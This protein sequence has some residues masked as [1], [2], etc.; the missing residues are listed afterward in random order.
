VSTPRAALRLAGTAGVTL[1]LLLPALVV[2]VARTVRLLREATALRALLRLQRLWSR[3][4]LGLLGVRVRLA[5]RPPDHGMLIVSNHL[6]YLDFPV[7]ASVLPCRFVAKREVAGWPVIGWLARLYRVLFLDRGRRRALVD[8]GAEVRR[9]LQ[10]GVA[11]VVF[12]EGTS[13]AGERVRPFHPGLLQ[14]AVEADAECLPLAIHYETPGDERPPAWTICWWGE[15]TFTPHV[16]ELMKTRSVEATL[17]FADRPERGDDRKRLAQA[18]HAR[19]GEL[20]RP[21]RQG[22]WRST[23][24]ELIEPCAR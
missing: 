18:L 15:M 20:F 11:V 17:S 9:S 4:V 23:E 10:A 5:G 16:W 21:V 13:T 1:V 19:I 14:P 12:P 24:E 2:A 7:I 6:G 8:V 3:Q 22:R